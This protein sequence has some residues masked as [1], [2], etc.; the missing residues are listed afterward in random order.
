MGCKNSKA[1]VPEQKLAEVPKPAK[2]AVNVAEQ[3]TKPA[4]VPKPAKEAVNV[5]EQGTKP[6]GEV[7][8]TEKEEGVDSFL[9]SVVE[10]I[11]KDSDGNLDANELKRELEGKSA[12]PE[13]L[14]KA[15]YNPQYYVLQQL[16][17]S[18]NG[19][20]SWEEFKASLSASVSDKD[21]A[22]SLLKSLFKQIDADTDGK[23]EKQEL[24]TAMKSEPKLEEMLQKANYNPQHYVLEQLDGNKDGK[25]SW[26]EFKACL[27]E[28]AVK[29]VVA[30]ELSTEEPS[31]VEAKIDT[32]NDSK[33]NLCFCW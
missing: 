19:K 4:E 12:L 11:D 3:V 6:A 24:A 9:K 26:D 27:E 31:T 8:K 20:V 29:Q 30:S 13:M 33:T 32:E 28:A 22:I 23:R 17:S 15:G 2:G 7:A 5:A 21:A 18:K 14:E 25:V 1:N 16:D 10:K